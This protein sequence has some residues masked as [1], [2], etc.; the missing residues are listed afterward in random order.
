MSKSQRNQTE[1]KPR[2]YLRKAALAERY[3][4][5]GRTIDRW[6]RDGSGRLPAP[7]YLAGD[8]PVWREDELDAHDRK[9]KREHHAKAKALAHR[10]PQQT[11]DA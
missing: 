1:R 10:F 8:F 3:S 4:V 9:E 5:S 7:T 11:A 6:S 2:K